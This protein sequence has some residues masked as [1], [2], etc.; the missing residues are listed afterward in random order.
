MKNLILISFIVLVSSSCAR[1]EL[2]AEQCMSLNWKE[3]GREDGAKADFSFSSYRAACEESQFIVDSESRALYEKGYGEKYCTVETAFMLGMSVESFDIDK[4]H[5]NKKKIL[6]YYVEG[7]KRG[8]LK[9]QISELKQ[10][11]REIES[12]LVAEDNPNL[13][14]EESRNLT[15]Q[16]LAYEKEIRELER[17]LSSLS[18]V[19]VE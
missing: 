8:T 16:K 17:E 6:K 11:K 7:K 5:S 14:E 15:L 10:K 18:D 1:V 3:K 2:S 13:T 12:D 4:C 9:K 19:Y